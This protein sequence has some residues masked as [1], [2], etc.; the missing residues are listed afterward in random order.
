[1][2]ECRSC[3]AE[4]R[5]VKLRPKLKNH[6]IDAI[7]RK[8]IVLSDVSEG[9]SPHAKIVDGYT[10]HFATCPDAAEFRR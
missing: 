3:G 1:M 8:V 4:I 5:W 9:G 7:S 2:A 6:P 10:S